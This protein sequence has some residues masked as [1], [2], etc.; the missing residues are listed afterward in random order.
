M[1]KCFEE[2]VGN[3]DRDDDEGDDAVKSNEGGS[4]PLHVTVSRVPP[5]FRKRLRVA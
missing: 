1:S 4:Q 3:Y 2:G 5:S